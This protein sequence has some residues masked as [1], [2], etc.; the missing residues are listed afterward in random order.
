[1][2]GVLVRGIC[3]ERC[4]GRLRL[5]PQSGKV[6]A[7]SII[8]PSVLRIRRDLYADAKINPDD[9]QTL[10]RVGVASINIGSFP[11]LRVKKRKFAGARS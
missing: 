5:R 1:M 2:P 6:V 3:I 8:S 7:T 4:W 10:G 9:L 11:T